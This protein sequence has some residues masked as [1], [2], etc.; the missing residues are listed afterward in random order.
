MFFSP[1]V[2]VVVCERHTHTSYDMVGARPVFL[3]RRG[4]GGVREGPGLVLE[5]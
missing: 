5:D 1:V 4:T 3:P 2:V